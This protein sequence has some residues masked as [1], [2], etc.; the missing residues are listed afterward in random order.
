[1]GILQNQKAVELKRQ[2]AIWLLVLFFCFSADVQDGLGPFLGVRLQQLGWSPESIGWALTLPALVGLAFSPLWGGVCDRIKHKR[3]LLAVATVMVLSASFVSMAGVPAQVFVA[4]IAVGVACAAFLPAGTALILGLSN[5]VPLSNVLGRT[6]AG[7]HAGTCLAAALAGLIGFLGWGGLGTLTAFWVM[8]GFALLSLIALGGISSDLIDN[9]AAR[10]LGQSRGKVESVKSLLTDPALLGLGLMLFFFHLGNA[11]ML[12][13]LGQAAVARFGI[14][15]SGAT[16]ATIFLA[17]LTMVVT[18]LLGARVARTHGF[19]HLMVTAFVALVIR[20]LI[21]G[22]WE[23]PWAIVPVQ[24]LDGVGAGLMG[25]ATPGM[26][27]VLLAGTGRVNLGLGSVL[28]M[29]GVGAGLSTA[30]GGHAVSFF[31]YEGAFLVLAAA[32]VVGLL[33]FVRSC[34]NSEFRTAAIKAV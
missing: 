5:G 7:K 33:V 17:Q 24:I 30:L 10:G 8:S 32:P 1:M 4:Q 34:A 28:L 31:G 20:G 18:A 22:F 26:V 9:D 16:G 15:P 25:V 13:L 11:A 23:S 21:A 27:A 14:D 19:G 2:R 3:A 12:P 6:E 29:Q